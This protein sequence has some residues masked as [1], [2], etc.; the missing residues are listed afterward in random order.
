MKRS[1]LILTAILL[2]LG[3]LQVRA[4][5]ADELPGILLIDPELL[6]SIPPEAFQYNSDRA[7]LNHFQR[8]LV[9]TL[10]LEFPRL[11][12]IFTSVHSFRL[13]DYGPLILIN[14]QPPAFYFTRPVLAQLEEHQ[15]AAEEQARLIGEQIDRAAQFI[16][17]KA[18]EAD[19]IQRIDL[20]M[21]SKKGKKEVVSL[22][23]DLEDVRKNLSSLEGPEVFSQSISIR[24]NSVDVDLDKMIAKNYQQ[25]IERLTAVL[26]DTL[27][28]T[29]P[30]LSDLKDNEKIC[31]N[32]HVR[33]NLTGSE[34][35]SILFVLSHSDIEAYRSGQFDLDA[36]KQRIAI[37]KEKE[38]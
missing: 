33:Q 8:N 13:P 19:L 22:Q 17:L 34:D 28:E 27:A 24:M 12:G 36:L 29:A 5:E 11:P 30:L 20:E 14:V 2:G 7:D 9:D 1:A 16:R 26:K 6:D 3:A 10:R 35:Q 15:R 18:K 25:L 32:A 31:I 37:T 4:Q 23:K 21:S 38:E